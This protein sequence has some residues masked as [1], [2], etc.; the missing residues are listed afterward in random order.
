MCFTGY[1]I[2]AKISH[3][4]NFSHNVHLDFTYQESKVKLSSQLIEILTTKV[5]E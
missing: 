2:L 5:F 3:E 4:E 1:L